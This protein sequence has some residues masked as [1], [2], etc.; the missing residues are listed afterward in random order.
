MPTSYPN[1][2]AAALIDGIISIDGTW[3][4]EDFAALA[5]AAK[6]KARL[7][8]QAAGTLPAAR[9]QALILPVLSTAEVAHQWDLIDVPT[10]FKA[11]GFSVQIE[12]TGWYEIFDEDDAGCG[13][14]LIQ[15]DCGVPLADILEDLPLLA[16]GQEG[17]SK[18]NFVVH[19]S[20]DALKRVVVKMTAARAA[21]RSNIP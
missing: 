13:E 20:D 19:G 16:A 4:W 1:L 14:L 17:T 21:A 3:T 11:L 12:G 9:R 15:I 5:A 10:H 8:K 18:N 7:C 6:E 2:K